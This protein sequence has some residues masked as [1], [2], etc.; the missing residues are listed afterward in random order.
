MV[1]AVGF[2]EAMKLIMEIDIKRVWTLCFMIQ[3]NWLVSG[4]RGIVEQ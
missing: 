2:N 1:K 3:I 4:V